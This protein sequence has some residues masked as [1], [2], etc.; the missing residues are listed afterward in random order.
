MPLEPSIKDKNGGCCPLR[1][2]GMLCHKQLTH[3]S[4]TDSF[5]DFLSPLHGRP[6]AIP[7]GVEELSDG[8]A[9]RSSITTPRRTRGRIRR[10]RGLLIERIQRLIR[11]PEILS[12]GETSG[13]TPN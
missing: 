9:L 12:F 3:L 2:I 6:G 11:E 10:L 13:L 8:A 5:A 7:C 1:R 4:H